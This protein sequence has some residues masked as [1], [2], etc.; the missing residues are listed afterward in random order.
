VGDI[1]A[2]VASALIL[3]NGIDWRWCIVIPAVLNGL[4]AIVNLYYIPNRPED[5]GYVYLTVY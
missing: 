5:I 1:I 2:A 4:W 3:S